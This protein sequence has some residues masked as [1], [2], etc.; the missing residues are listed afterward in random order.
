MSSVYQ[1]LKGTTSNV[2]GVRGQSE[3]IEDQRKVWAQDF[4]AFLV[5]QRIFR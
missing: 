2:R 4:T 3:I 1:Y 5:D